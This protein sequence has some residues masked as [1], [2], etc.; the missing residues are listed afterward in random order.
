MH[1]CEVQLAVVGLQDEEVWV[2]DHFIP[3]KLHLAYPALMVLTAAP[4]G[5]EA[6]HLG[7]I[8]T[9]CAPCYHT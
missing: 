4:F 9:V 3:P 8:L 2:Y 5:T 7:E 1:W 6:L